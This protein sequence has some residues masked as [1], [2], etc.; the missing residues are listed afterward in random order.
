M[1]LILILTALL[2]FESAAA[3]EFDETKALADLGHAEAQH[4]LGDM[5]ADGQGVPENDAEAV[6]WYRTAAE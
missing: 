6:S 2:A 1:R 3:S 4:I 5:Y